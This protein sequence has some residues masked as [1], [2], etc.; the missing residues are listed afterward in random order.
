MGGA[1]LVGFVAGGVALAAFFA[2]V[3]ARSGLLERRVS[4]FPTHDVDHSPADVGLAFENV[5]LETSDGVS[6]H[7]WFVPGERDVTILWMHGN[8]GN[9]A[10]HLGSLP[11]L[12]ARLG[13]SLFLFDYRGF[14]L[15][16]GTPGEHGFYRDATAAL[17]YLRSRSDVRND[18]I[19]YF[20]QS[21]GT[22]VAI[23]LATR[24][25]PL[26]IIL[27]AP[28]PSGPYMAHR[29]VPSLPMWFHR[30][31][32]PNRYDSLS[33]LG[34]IHAPMLVV[35][36][37]QDATVPHEAGQVVFEAANEPKEMV[38]IPGGGHVDSFVVDGDV[39]FEALTR[40]L[41]RLG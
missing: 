6:L 34:R 25:A 24:A 39:Y 32:I 40:F 12:H 33:R 26:G 22:A 15:S 11:D 14:G 17:D 35:H 3:F 36:G 27:E 30:Y 19:V 20:G 9:I 4:Y 16:D 41:D 2:V 31:F 8:G 37:D 21:L 18:R 5:R 13:V 7:G 38:T 10:Y 23:E 29:L 28:F 1:A